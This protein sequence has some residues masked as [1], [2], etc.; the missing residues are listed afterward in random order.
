M[1]VI[2]FRRKHWP[3]D[4][5]LVR[6]DVYA[7]KDTIDQKVYL[8]GMLYGPRESDVYGEA[9]EIELDEVHKVQPLL[10]ILNIDVGDP[11]MTFASYALN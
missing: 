6:G 3:V 8:R 9:I 1:T 5:V 2:S 11:D 4:S 10:N 7:E